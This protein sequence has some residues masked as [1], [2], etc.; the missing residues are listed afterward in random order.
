[1]DTPSLRTR[2]VDRHNRCLD[3]ATHHP[4]AHRGH[5]RRYFGR[6]WLRGARRPRASVARVRLHQST[7]STF[8]PRRTSRRGNRRK[9]VRNRALGATGC[10]SGATK[11]HEARPTKHGRGRDFC[12]VLFWSRRLL[13]NSKTNRSCRRGR[14]L[15]DIRVVHF[16][17]HDPRPLQTRLDHIRLA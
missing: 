14:R 9:P 17:P 5:R 1:M 12:T 2:I 6:D 7:Y 16:P 4:F 15:G 13:S 11:C 3:A 8:M 10:H